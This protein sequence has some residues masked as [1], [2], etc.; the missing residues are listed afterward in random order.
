MVELTPGAKLAGATAEDDVYS[1]AAKITT[2]GATVR[3]LKKA[4]AGSEEIAAAVKILTD[5]KAHLALLEAEVTPTESFNREAFDQLV[6]RKMYVVPSFEIHNGPAGLFDYGPPACTL[7]ANIINMWRSHFVVEESMLEMECTNLTPSQV[8]ETSGHVERFTDFM[9]R[10]EKT[11]E[12]FRADVL[13]EQAIDALLAANPYMP[14]EE[15]EAHE[16]VQRQ[17]DAY[18]EDELDGMLKKYNVMS[19]ANAEN[20]L[21]KPFPF[22]LMFKTMIGPDGKQVGFLRPETAQ[23]LF[24]NFKR[25]LEYNSGKVPFAAAQIG[26]GFRNEIAPAKGLLRVREFCMGE[27]EHFVNP[28]DKTCA[29]FINVADKELCL[30]SADDQLKTGRT[31]VKT[32]GAAVKEGLVGNETLGY[33]MA[34]TQQWLENIGVDPARM[35][36]RQ[37]LKTEMAHYAADCWDMEINVSYGWVECVGH[38][39]RACFDLEQHA[40]ATKTPMLASELLKT[41]IEVESYLCE[42]NKKKIGPK[43]KM[44]Q[45][46]IINALEGLDNDGAKELEAALAANGTAEVAGFEIT[47]DLV[48][49]K[50]ENKTVQETKFTPHVIEPS[51]GMGRI[52]Y[53]VLEH[54]FSQREGAEERSVMSFRPRIAPVKVA[55][56]RLINNTALDTIV[57]QVD[58]MASAGG[59]VTRVDSSAVTV[60][61][62]YARADELGIP[63]GVTVDFESTL[64][65]CVTIRERD[66]MAQVRVPLTHVISVL[67]A[68]CSET[69]AWKNMMSRYPLVAGAGDEEEES[70][71]NKKKSSEKKEVRPLTVDNQKRAMFSRPTIAILK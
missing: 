42:P 54:S 32:I 48:S 27:I 30:F 33:F 11:G 57:S 50:K 39:D 10:D 1:M 47:P 5:L 15:R 34:R 64:D 26:L 29:K 3:T 2:Q 41:P 14:K 62:R 66:S 21:T 61:R 46:A 23:G 17:A 63:F 4:Q 60:G 8:L 24:V 56:F 44:N 45:K 31:V 13:L 69:V 28:N 6:V 59:L 19:P 7:K 53:A 70:S 43:F 55:I 38:A 35:R 65:N 25:L 71:D 12:C 58:D 36:F 22:N 9:V 68:L 52:I 20:A 18:S 51:F 16:V 40:A 37:H 67:Q 49:F